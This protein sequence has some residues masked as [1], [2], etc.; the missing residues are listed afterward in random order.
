[1][2]VHETILNGVSTNVRQLQKKADKC[3]IKGIENIISQIS[4]DFN[5]IDNIIN[6]DEELEQYE[7]KNPEE[8]KYPPIID[9]NSKRKY[10]QDKKDYREAI[11]TLENECKCITIE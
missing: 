10:L 2:N 11:N 1:M 5:R 6:R 9:K 7:R 4:V 3:D 8:N